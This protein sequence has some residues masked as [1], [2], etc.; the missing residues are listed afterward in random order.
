[1][2]AAL[3]TVL[4]V[5]LLPR[6]ALDVWDLIVRVTRARYAEQLHSE[7]AESI[8]RGVNLADSWPERAGGPQ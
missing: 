2:T 8:A 6:A 4:V 5:L 7:L 1:M 3:L